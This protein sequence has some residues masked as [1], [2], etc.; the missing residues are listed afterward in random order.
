MTPRPLYRWKS[1]WFGMLVI[2]FL[3]WA[4]AHSMRHSAVIYLWFPH[5]TGFCLLH[6]GE[7]T[8]AV[9]ESQ[10]REWSIYSHFDSPSQENPWFQ[11]AVELV[12]FDEWKGL[13]LAHWFLI[14]LFLVPWSGWLAWRWC[15][16]KRLSM[17]GT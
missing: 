11:P 1:F 6:G 14:L 8:I 13:S 16:I 17:P 2:A 10:N 15:K 7:L 3:G 12:P 4:W 5:K 9:M